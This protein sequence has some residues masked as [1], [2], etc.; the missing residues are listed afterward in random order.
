VLACRLTDAICRDDL[1]TIRTLVTR[2]PRL[3]Q[4]DARA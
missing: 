3:L 2:H 4:E 1:D